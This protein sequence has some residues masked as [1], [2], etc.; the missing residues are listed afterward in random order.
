MYDVFISYSRIDSSI[1]QAI[2]NGLTDK[3]LNVFFDMESIRSESFPAKIAKGI[4]ESKIILFISAFV[5]MYILF[6]INLLT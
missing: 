1:A 4:K 6:L 3:G 2:Y 5:P